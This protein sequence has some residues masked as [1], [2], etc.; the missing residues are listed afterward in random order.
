MANSDARETESAVAL[1][2]PKEVAPATADSNA[3]LR[4]DAAPGAAADD[5]GEVLLHTEREDPAEGEVLPGLGRGDRARVESLW[6]GVAWRG[7]AGQGVAGQG[8]AGQGGEGFAPPHRHPACYRHRPATAF[9][10]AGCGLLC[11]RA[12]WEVTSSQC[13]G[14][15]KFIEMLQHADSWQ[16]GCVTASDQVYDES[17]DVPEVLVT[18]R[19][20]YNQPTPK[21]NQ[22]T[23]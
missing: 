3:A 23:M 9:R 4:V 8:V 16:L 15:V 5:A 2:G 22:D 21:K 7:V 18:N 17:V 14:G 1:P 11:A 13:D 10:P 20:V 19:F 6:T 12:E